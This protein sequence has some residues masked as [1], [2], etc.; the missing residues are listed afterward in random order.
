MEKK[1]KVEFIKETDYKGETV[2]YTRKDGRLVP[3]SLRF[4]ENTA[5][6]VYNV[7]VKNGSTEPKIEILETNYN[8]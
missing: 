2:Y 5:R 8:G 1:S 7:V 6:E 3:D 4:N